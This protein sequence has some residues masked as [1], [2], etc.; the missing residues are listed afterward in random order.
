MTLPNFD[1]LLLDIIS[2]KKP[3]I[4]KI[5]IAKAFRNVC[6]DPG[7]AVKL[8]MQH[9]GEC[10]E[11]RSLAFGTVHGTAIFQRIMDEKIRLYN[12][13]DNIFACTESEVALA[14]FHRA[15]EIIEEL[16]DRSQKKKIMFLHSKNKA[17]RK[18]YKGEC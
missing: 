4:F 6:I 11:D 12:Y 10:Y 17:S 15:K 14:V 2:K 18:G 16:E 1:S 3:K 7:D 9:E 5:D 8:T 13:I